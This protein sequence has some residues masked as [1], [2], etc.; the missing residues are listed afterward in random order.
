MKGMRIISSVALVMLLLLSGL[1]LVNPTDIEANGEGAPAR[2]TLYGH[3]ESYNKSFSKPTF[4]GDSDPNNGN[5]YV[6]ENDW[7]DCAM[8]I[9]VQDKHTTSKKENQG[10]GSG[11]AQ[12]SDIY[13][14]VF[15]P[16]DG[17]TI[18]TG[19]KQRIMV[20]DFTATWC[21]YCTAVIGA[22]ERLDHDDNWFP[23]KYIGVEYH[24]SGTYGTGTPASTH[25]TRQSD[26]QIAGGIPRYIIDGWDPWVG[27]STD[28]NN[29]AIESRIKNSIDNRHT[30]ASL[31]IEATAHHNSNNAWV[32][33]KVTVEDQS[34]DNILV[35]THVLLV[36][37]AYPRRHGTNS[38]AYLGLIA[39]DMTSF[40]IFTNIEGSDPVISN[41]QPAADSVISGT[42]EIKFDVTDVDASDDKITK[43]V[44]I[45]KAGGSWS[46]LSRTDGKYLWI[47]DDKSGEEYLYPDGDYEIRISATDYWEETATLTIPV[48][49]F[50]PDAPV[51]HF[52]NDLMEDQL[53]ETN[54]VSGEIDILWYAEDDEDPDGELVVDLYYFQTGGPD[55]PI[56]TGL[57]NTGSYTWDTMNPERI[58]DD[59]KNGYWLKATVTDSD[60]MT[61]EEDSKIK[62]FINNPDPPM[63][64]V[65]TPT[66]GQELSGISSIR[67]EASDG[68]DQSGDLLIDIELSKDDGDTWQMLK[69]DKQN[70]EASYRFDTSLWDDG[71]YIAR[72]TV[73]DLSKS[74]AS[75]ISPKFWI[76]NNDPPTCSFKDIED[77]QVISGEFDITWEASDEEDAEEDLSY[78]LYYMDSTT[79]E[80]QTLV[81]GEPNEGVFTLDTADY[82]DGNYQFKLEVVDS[83]DERSGSALIY[84]DIYN[85]DTPTILFPS[86]PTNPVS[87]MA[88]F[89]WEAEDEDAGE[90]PFLKLSVYISQDG[91]S[92]DPVEEEIGNINEY[93]LDV[94]DLEDGTYQVKIVI[95]D[96]S[97]YELSDEYIFTNVVVNN[98]DPP[99]V[100]FTSAPA[101]G[102]NVTEDVSFDWSGEDP[103]DDPLTYDLYYRTAGE[104]SW[105]PIEG[106]LDLPDT[107]FV[108]NI[109]GLDTGDYEVKIVARDSTSQVSEEIL[110]VFH[111]YVDDT[112]DPGGQQGNGGE[113]EQTDEGDDGNFVVIAGVI[114]GV[115]LLLIVILL[116]VLLIVKRKKQSDEL[117]RQPPGGPALGQGSTEGSQQLPGDSRNLSG[118][119]LNQ[120]EQKDNPQLPPTD[121]QNVSGGEMN[122]Q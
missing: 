93:E 87:G 8:V 18:K 16:L 50:N 103:D 25:N 104:S 5:A 110:P 14:A 30:T 23:E 19:T 2:S 3:N 80:W 74:T 99:T 78:Y 54:R 53:S 15:V 11:T 38:N 51:I 9:M 101:E 113:E 91:S 33:F 12:C 122:Q 107:S 119:Q 28:P 39:Q 118:G 111:V 6:E 64:T 73:E 26:Y 47:T 121:S 71:E 109:S 67:W 1:T 43:K 13:Q 117:F 45:R 4:Y 92:W 27:G 108:W 34:F 115:I 55:I 49:I 42:Q 94:S 88:E 63:I 7:D 52:K 58:P 97:E 61:D 98:P 22:M 41:V 72:L 10:T 57:E 114:I 44:E 21:G 20:E 105:T 40:D 95:E 83:K 46:T 112:E 116:V 31:S 96:S 59:I 77:Y 90:E 70:N 84:L 86:G 75:A 37:D 35:E 48:T 85:P 102:E 56:A 29:T 65:Q 68:E 89:S 17:T 81:A 106:G 100:E 120:L 60:E 36:Q 69:E 24:G 82:E 79:V 76:Y 66:E 62:I 32:N